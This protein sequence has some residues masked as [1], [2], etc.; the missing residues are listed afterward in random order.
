MLLQWLRPPHQMIFY[1]YLQHIGTFS[2]TPALRF[3]TNIYLHVSEPEM[4][5]EYSILSDFL[6][7]GMCTNIYK[8]V[9]FNPTP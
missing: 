3:H 9:G 8:H 7:P 1:D 2:T 5:F 6:P 4:P